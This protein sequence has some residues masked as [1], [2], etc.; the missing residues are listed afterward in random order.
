[1]KKFTCLYNDNKALFSI[2]L[3]DNKL[4]FLISGS[5]SWLAAEAAEYADCIS[6]NS[7]GYDV[8]SSDGE[9]PV[10]EVWRM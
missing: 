3:A 4:N 9:T 7:P 8:K 1:M 2:Y 6:N 5:L 10:L